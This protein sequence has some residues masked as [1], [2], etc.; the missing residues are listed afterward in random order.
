MTNLEAFLNPQPHKINFPE[1]VAE[2]K[3]K[4]TQLQGLTDFQVQE[5]WS[6]WGEG[7]YCAGWLIVSDDT[8]KE[9]ETW[10]NQ[11]EMKNSGWWDS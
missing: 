5:L 1:D 4:I 7:Y 11:D 9:F 8:I 6:D 3:A 10:L 2:I